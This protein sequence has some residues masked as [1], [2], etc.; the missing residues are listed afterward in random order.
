MSRQHAEE[1]PGSASVGRRSDGLPGISGDVWVPSRWD[2]NR[3]CP[4]AALLLD[5]PSARSDRSGG[6]L[7]GHPHGILSE[8]SGSG[9]RPQST[10][11]P[12]TTREGRAMVE[13]ISKASTG[14][15]GSGFTNV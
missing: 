14:L 8:T 10:V 11:M 13:W 9:F 2:P 3:R 6:P 1:A 15:S 7:P 4:A 12:E 5:W